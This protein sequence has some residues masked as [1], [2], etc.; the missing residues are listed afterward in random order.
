MDHG[1]SP[2]PALS[3]YLD[4][5]RIGR[6]AAA[7][8][9]QAGHIEKARALAVRLHRLYPALKV[10]GLQ[11]TLGPYRRPESLAKYEEAIRKAGLME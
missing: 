2:G 9:A 10:S 5:K 6:V 8:N 4:I 3:R 1:A 11:S 7:V